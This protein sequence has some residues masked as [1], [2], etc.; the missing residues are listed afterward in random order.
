MWNIGETIRGCHYIETEY[1]RTK[2]QMV[3]KHRVKHVSIMPSE[4]YFY[5]TAVIDDEHVRKN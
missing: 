3:V 1:L 4:Y 5:L 2:D